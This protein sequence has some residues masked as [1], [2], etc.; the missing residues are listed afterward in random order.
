[1]Y[2]PT[3]VHI[4]IYIRCVYTCRDLRTRACTHVRRHNIYAI[5]RTIFYPHPSCSEGCSAE[6]V[7]T[8]SFTLVNC[9]KF[10]IVSVTDSNSENQ[11]TVCGTVKKVTADHICSALDYGTAVDYGTADQKR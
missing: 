7:G 1:M 4:Y 9:Q 8:F 10:G 3:Y 11:G 5:L 6:T 2:V